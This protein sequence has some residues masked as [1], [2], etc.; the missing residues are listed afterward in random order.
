MCFSYAVEPILEYSGVGT[1][2]VVVRPICY[3]IAAIEST[4]GAARHGRGAIRSERASMD[5]L[6]RT[7]SWNLDIPHALPRYLQLTTLDGALG[8]FFATTVT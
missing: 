7:V 6:P 4:A 2:T 5:H 1:L 3:G 8:E